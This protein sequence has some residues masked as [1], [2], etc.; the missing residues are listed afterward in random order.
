MGILKLY[1]NLAVKIGLN[2][3]IFIQQVHY[4]CQV[5]EKR[6]QNQKEGHYWMYSTLEGWQEQLPFWSTSTIKRIIAKLE[7]QGYL[8]SGNFNK[9]KID[10]T[11]WYRVDYEKLQHDSV[12]NK[13]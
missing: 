4:W 13:G 7:N 9:M 1:V 11:K 5:N 2:E 8:I 10:R 12:L 3:A 6:G